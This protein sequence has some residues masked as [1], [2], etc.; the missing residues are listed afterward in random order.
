MA[1]KNALAFIAVRDIE[2]SA[3]WYRM[4]LGREPDTQ[5]MKGLA[6]WQFEAG[7]WLQVN[8]NK[9]LAGRSSVTLVETDLDDRINKLKKAGIEPKSVMRGEQV[10]VAIITDPDGNQVVFAQ[11]RGEKHRAV[12]G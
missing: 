5:P 12:I 6:E 9:Q 4:L 7:G 3:R 2:A 1:L 11:G 8:E 10:S